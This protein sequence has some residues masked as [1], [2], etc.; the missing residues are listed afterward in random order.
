MSPRTKWITYISNML[1][2]KLLAT[3]NKQGV[4]KGIQFTYDIDR[5]GFDSFKL[6]V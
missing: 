1:L 4:S 6:L 3:T 2:E 5:Y